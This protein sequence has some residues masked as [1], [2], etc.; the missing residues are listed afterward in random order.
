MDLLGGIGSW[1][2]GSSGGVNNALGALGILGNIY[3]ANQQA[4]MAKKQFNLQ[5]DAFNYNKM[6]SDYALNMQKKRDKEA[7]EAYLH[8][9]YMLG[10]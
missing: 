4:K 1:M 5:K 6:L 2:G 8:S 10:A 9:S 3:G 7:D